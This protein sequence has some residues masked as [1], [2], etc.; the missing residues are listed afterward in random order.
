M[1]RWHIVPIIAFV[2]LHPIRYLTHETL[3]DAG[4]DAVFDEVV[5]VLVL[6][7]LHQVKTILQSN[8]TD[9]LNTFP[10][11]VSFD[12]GHL[13][14]AVLFYSSVVKARDD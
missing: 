3:R 8:V 5:W 10:K 14:F 2:L 4:L 6:V 12:S 7:D 11:I 13:P 9:A 1:S